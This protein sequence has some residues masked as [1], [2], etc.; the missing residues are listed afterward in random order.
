MEYG[1]NI[2]LD[3]APQTAYACANGFDDTITTHVFTIHAHVRIVFVV[4][5]IAEI[6][7]ITHYCEIQEIAKIGT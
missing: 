4:K 1:G 5:E 3:I 2:V 6:S 7:T